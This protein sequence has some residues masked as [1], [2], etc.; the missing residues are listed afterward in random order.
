MYPTNDNKLLLHFNQSV[1]VT[2]YIVAGG[3]GAISISGFKRSSEWTIFY[4][5]SARVHSSQTRQENHG[6]NAEITNQL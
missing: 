4:L 6:A 2:S 3:N 1:E 5:S